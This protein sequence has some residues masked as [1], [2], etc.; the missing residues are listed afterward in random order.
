[1]VV[2]VIPTWRGL[3]T[4]LCTLKENRIKVVTSVLVIV[5]PVPITSLLFFFAHGHFLGKQK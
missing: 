3:V 2:V 4:A 1:M 5:A